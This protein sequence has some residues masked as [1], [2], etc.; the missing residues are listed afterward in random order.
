MGRPV[1]PIEHC[2]ALGDLGDILLADMSQYYLATKGGVQMASS[3][4]V[5]FLTDETVFRFVYRVDGQPS[6]NVALTPHL[7]TAGQTLSPFV[8]LAARP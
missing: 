6:W 4:H 7:S 5:Q 3:I 8:T 2:S 1:I